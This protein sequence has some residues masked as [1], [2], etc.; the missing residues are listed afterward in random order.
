MKNVNIYSDGACSGN[1]GP[2]GYGVILEYNGKEME[3]S[4]GEK[5]TTNNKM[6]LMGVIIGLEALKES[7][8]VIVTTDSKY[9]TDAFNKGWLK[10]WQKKNWKKAD[11]KPVLNQELWQRLLNA[12]EKHNV[13][14]VHVLGHNGHEYNERCDK[15]AVSERDKYSAE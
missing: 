2:G 14:F 15:L 7:C 1:P 13:K 3:L 9:V 10:S 4:G 11:G 5:I 8:D 12:V 6:E